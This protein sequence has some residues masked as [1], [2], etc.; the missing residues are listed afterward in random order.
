MTDRVQK[1]ERARKVLG[2]RIRTLRRRKGWIQLDL[3]FECGVS[4]AAISK[5]ELGQVNAKIA[6]LIKIARALRTDVA[7]LFRGL[8]YATKTQ[9]LN[10]RRPSCEENNLNEQPKHRLPGNAESGG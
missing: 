6:S 3:A 8:P 9:T 5:I 1:S 2:K 4:P 10:L 7:R